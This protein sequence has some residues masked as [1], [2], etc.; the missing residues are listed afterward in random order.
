MPPKQ[1]KKTVQKEQAKKIEDQTFGL[2]NKNRSAKVAAYCQSVASSVKSG[3][4]ATIAN[5]K[6][7]EARR[8]AKE[9]KKLFEAAMAKLTGEADKQPRRQG[10]GSSDDDDDE[11][12][13]DGDKNLGVA[14]E[15]YLWTADD[16]DEVAHDGSRLEERLEA[17]R[18]ALK[19]RT[20][21]T[22]VTEESFLAWRERKKAEAAAKEK[23]RLADAKSGKGKLRGWDLWQEKKELFVDDEDGEEAYVKEFDDAAL[24]E[25]D[26]E[27]GEDYDLGD[28][29]AAPAAAAAAAAPQKKEEGEDDDGDADDKE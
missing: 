21:L 12:G 10:Q 22:P 29:G 17:E 13:E 14:P 20:D 8:K 6:E 2:K 16:F 23:Q 9:E 27:E 24:F 19:E 1:S 7:L 11:E 15:N 25:G 5:E 4:K 3:N 28:E 26:G 18:E